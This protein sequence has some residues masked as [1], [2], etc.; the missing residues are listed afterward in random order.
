MFRTLHALGLVAT[1]GVAACDTQPVG[2]ESFL[3]IVTRSSGPESITLG[4]A[5]TL[6]VS[7][8]SG[9]LGIDVTERIAPNDTIVLSVPPATYD[10]KID[11]LPL[12]CQAREGTAQRSVIFEPGQTT[13]VRFVLTCASLLTVRTASDGTLLD[14]DFVVRHTDPAG[15]TTSRLIAPNDTVRLDDIAPGPNRI[16]LLHVSPRCV[17]MTDGGTD[18]RVDIEL[19]RPQ[20]VDFRLRCTDP[21]LA[22]ETVHFGSSYRDSVSVFYLEA[23]DPDPNGPAEP[24]FPDL[25][26]YI[27]N[28]TDCRTRSILGDPSRFDRQGFSVSGLSRPGSPLA[29]ADTVRVAT[30]LRV[31][32]PDGSVQD[33]CT[34]M[35]VEDWRGNSS[36][37]VLDRIG[38]EVGSPPRVAWFDVRPTRSGSATFL[39]FDLVAEDPDDDFA[40][41]FVFFVFHDG[42]FGQEDGQPEILSLRLEGF[43]GSEITDLLM[44]TPSF[45]RNFTPDDILR[46][47][48]YATDR[49][50]NFTTAFD[51]DPRG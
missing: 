51:E 25:D 50:G 15:R 35:R 30:V 40:A 32:L 16:E 33:A 47:I 21:A 3:A 9:T 2:T 43:R 49:E 34:S 24:P 27:W 41:S 8:T 44:T 18:Q 1:L 17:V 13:T 7:E 42:T 12:A 31:G 4:E 22:P 37:V 10:V 36:G 28:L 6:S 29:G 14:D 19:N 46:V 45:N 38:D 48:V 26:R 39:T 5:W 23:V 11:G 20:V